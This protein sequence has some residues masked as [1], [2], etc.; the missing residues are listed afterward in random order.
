MS[1]SRAS[2]FVALRRLAAGSKQV[3]KLHMT[4]PATYASPMLTSERRAVNLP[5]DINSLRAECKKRNL[6]TAG[7]K[8]QLENRLNADEMTRGFSTAVDTTKRPEASSSRA[9]TQPTRHFNTSRTLKAVN[10]T[11]TIDFA[12]LPDFN[13]DLGTEAPKMRVPF[14]PDALPQ[15]TGGV[16]YG[17]EVEEEVMRPEISTVAADSTHIS[18]PSAMSDVHDNA[19]VEIDFTSI[20]DK[21]QAAAKRVT[22]TV[23]AEEQGVV[24]EV[25]DGF[26]EDI[27]GPKRKA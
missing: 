7:D 10:D 8:S 19:S 23:P 5:R 26:L 21:V 3:R 11:S 9:P 16:A 15:K 2:S 24:R 12:Y 25:W 4:G 17:E 13:P 22:G 18:A 27:F 1:A 20:V 14:V 6:L